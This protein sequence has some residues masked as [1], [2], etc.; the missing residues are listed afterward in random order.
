[1]YV[2]SGT[3][4]VA[5]LTASILT[6]YALIDAQH[7]VRAEK[8]YPRDKVNRLES[9]V[10]TA[11]Y[12]TSSIIGW[13]RSTQNQSLPVQ[14]PVH[15]SIPSNSPGNEIPLAKNGDSHPEYG[16]TSTGSNDGKRR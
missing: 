6:V 7:R 13:R 3:A 2:S 1:M 8:L 16:A 14:D 12:L 10:T 9:I 4:T 11:R 5:T 15:G